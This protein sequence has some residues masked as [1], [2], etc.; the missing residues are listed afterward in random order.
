[1]IVFIYIDTQ[2]HKKCPEKDIAK[3]E[4]PLSLGGRIIGTFIFF[5]VVSEK[6]LILLNQ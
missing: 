3:G 2:M 1:M 6:H 5:S 4:Q